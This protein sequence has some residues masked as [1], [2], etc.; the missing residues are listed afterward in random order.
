M[1]VGIGTDIIDMRRIYALFQRYG[2]RFIDKIYTPQEQQYCLRKTLQPLPHCSLTSPATNSKA[3]MFAAKE[4][5]IKILGDTK[6]LHWHD[7]EVQH[8][9]NG[10]PKIALH[11]QGHVLASALCGAAPWTFH[12]SLADDPPYA[13]AYAALSCHTGGTVL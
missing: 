13:I 9:A 10:Q 1:L 3:K 11:G 5:V 7:I 12:L 2:Q 8:S 4:A 6:G